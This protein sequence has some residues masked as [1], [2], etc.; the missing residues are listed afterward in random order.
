[1]LLPAIA[2]GAAVA[3]LVLSFRKQ[4]DATCQAPLPK[5]G[6]GAPAPENTNQAS[7]APQLQ[8]AALA[9]VASRQVDRKD[10]DQICTENWVYSF[11]P[12][13]WPLEMALAKAYQS[14]MPFP[15]CA[16]RWVQA[17]LSFGSAA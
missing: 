5:G 12:S 9:N 8:S 15:A 14:G 7:A 11:Y 13:S 4:A 2:V 6:D 17:R 1:M 16:K 10:A 3:A